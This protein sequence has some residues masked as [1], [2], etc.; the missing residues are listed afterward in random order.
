MAPDVPR[1]T[2]AVRTAC[3]DVRGIGFASWTAAPPQ[4]TLPHVQQSLATSE[5]SA[6]TARSAT[7]PEAAPGTTLL[8]I[9]GPG[10]SNP[11]DVIAV[12][13]L[14]RET[15]P[16]L[17]SILVN[18]RAG[19]SPPPS[20]STCH[21]PHATCLA[22]P[23]PALYAFLHTSA[24]LDATWRMLVM[25]GITPAPWPARHDETRRTSWRREAS[26]EELSWMRQPTSLAAFK[27]GWFDGN[28][29]ESQ[30]YEEYQNAPDK[31]RAKFS[32]ELIGGAAA[33]EAA[34]AYEDH[35]RKNGKP[36]SHAEAK[37]ILAGLAGAFI[38]REFE[39][40]GLN[41][42]DRERAKHDAHKRLNEQVQQDY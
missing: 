35:V 9:R 6:A 41:T 26:R 27:M 24:E 37:E 11:T 22:P 31:H 13:S 29:D 14:P 12:A 40:R 8:S 36:A 28:T 3:T 15:S 5:P 23:R 32:H 18:A 19:F 10:G 38:D 17:V 33:F 1:F 2:M 20:P 4:S 34:K 42:I 7:K 39:T 30:A 25:L 16:A 21:T